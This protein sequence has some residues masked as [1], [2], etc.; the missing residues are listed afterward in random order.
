MTEE[1]KEKKYWFKRK[2]YGWG[3]TP[4][5]WQGWMVV[6]VWLLLFIF[7]VAKMDHEGLKN[8]AVVIF[9]TI[10]LLYICY[11]KG[12]KPHWQWGPPKDKKL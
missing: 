8:I 4:I 11:K 5:T 10:I 1:Q 3:W 12:E 2:N 6:L 7:G 9:M